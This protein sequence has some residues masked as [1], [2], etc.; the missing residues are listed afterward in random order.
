LMDATEEFAVPAVVDTPARR[1]PVG[2]GLARWLLRHQVQPVG[3][4]TGEGHALPHAWWKVMSLTGVDY[5]SS[6]AYVPAIAALAAG[7]VSPLATL[8]IVEIGRASCRERV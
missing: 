6:L 3:P 8:L 1:P 4:E 7:A 2:G 5:F